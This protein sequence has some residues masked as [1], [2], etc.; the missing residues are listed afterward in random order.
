LP[1]ASEV[2]ILCFG[3]KCVHSVAAPVRLLVQFLRQ[4]NR[5]KRSERVLLLSEQDFG[6]RVACGCSTEATSI[7]R[8]LELP[9][10]VC[11][12]YTGSS[13]GDKFDI[14]CGPKMKTKLTVVT[15]SMLFLTDFQNYFT[16]NF[17]VNLQQG[18][19]RGFHHTQM[20]RYTTF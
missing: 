5:T 10:L 1:S 14:Q 11:I 16:L 2:S 8:I 20:R 15:P 9:S 13:F 6:S 17:A 18:D 7:G 4:V 3:I 12:H 19:N